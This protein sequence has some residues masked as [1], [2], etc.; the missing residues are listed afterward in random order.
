VC[1]SQI[2]RKIEA[3]EQRKRDETARAKAMATALA[4]I[5]KFAIKKKVGDADQIFGSVTAADVVAAIEQQARLR[6]RPYAVKVMYRVH[7]LHAH[8]AQWCSGVADPT[9]SRVV[10]ASM[11]HRPE[12]RLTE[13]CFTPEQCDVCSQPLPLF[14][15]WG[16]V[17][18]CIAPCHL[19]AA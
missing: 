19:S 6:A 11:K 14:R 2:Q 8:P 9:H 1:R 18:M 13:V 5:G 12:L 4:T 7:L 16:L 17:V 3:E 10:R 15:I